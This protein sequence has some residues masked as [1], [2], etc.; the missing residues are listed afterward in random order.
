MWKQKWKYELFLS[1]IWKNILVPLMRFY[2]T[3]VETNSKNDPFYKSEKNVQVQLTSFC[4]KLQKKKMSFSFQIWKKCTSELPLHKY[5]NNRKKWIS[6]SKSE[7]KAT[8]SANELLLHKC[9]NNRKTKK[10]IFSSSELKKF[11]SLA[12]L[13]SATQM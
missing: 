5:R 1:K 6:Y 9:R 2:Y 10:I 8:S 4:Y 13:V 11:T 3:N 12:S 7:K